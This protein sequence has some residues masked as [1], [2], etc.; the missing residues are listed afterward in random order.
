MGRALRLGSTL[1]AVAVFAASAVAQ[2]R[3]DAAGATAP[4]A[5]SDLSVARPASSP[6]GAAFE[7]GVAAYDRGQFE[8]AFAL[9]LPLAEQ[10]RVA[11]QFNLAAL[12]ENGQGVAQNDAEAARWYLKAAEQGD[13]EAQVRVGSL[14]EQGKGVPRDLDQAS[15][16]YGK[17]LAEGRKAP[18]QTVQ[19]ARERLAALS[20]LDAPGDVFAYPGGRFVIRS[21]ES[22]ECV[23]ALQGE[24]NRRASAA[25]DKV[26]AETASRRCN[27]PATLLLESP[28]GVVA[29]GLWLGTQVRKGGLRTVARYGCASSCGLIF[30]GGVDRVLWG[31]RAAIGF[32]QAAWSRGTV[33]QCDEPDSSD[34]LKIRD[35]LRSVIPVSADE[36]FQLAMS[37]SCDAISWVRGERALQLGVATALEAQGVDVFG[38][39]AAREQRP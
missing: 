34:S 10:G 8:R 23:I 27:R 32:H 4:A 22:G 28:G 2:P 20:R 17:V 12:Y 7:E 37:T 36:V 38:P 9:W 11:A 24:I 19:L 35:Y 13:A 21:A 14:F 15:Y 25:F 39:K 6:G 1:A 18:R 30:L 29:D 16:W 5:A 33:R 26:L 3:P 31:A